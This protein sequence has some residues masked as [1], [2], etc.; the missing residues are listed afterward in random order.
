MKMTLPTLAALSMILVVGCGRHQEDEPMP[1][2]DRTNQSQIPDAMC[3]EWSVVSFASLKGKSQGDEVLDTWTIDPVSIRFGEAGV[4]QVREVQARIDPEQDLRLVSFADNGLQ[5]A[6]I[7]SDTFPE[8]F[9]VT[10]YLG[11]EEKMRCLLTKK[12]PEELRTIASTVRAGA[13]RP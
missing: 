3:G 7:R 9:L 5:C 12:T 8:T 10:Q 1:H 13:A 6:F 2:G 11:R 4:L